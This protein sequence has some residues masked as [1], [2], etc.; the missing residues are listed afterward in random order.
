MC[1]LNL[2]II[3][4]NTYYTTKIAYALIKDLCSE[5]MQKEVFKLL[6]V[7]LKKNTKK[8]GKYTMEYTFLFSLANESNVKVKLFSSTKAKF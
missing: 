6:L 4:C 2:L 8:L 5:Y 1:P 7:R 3:G